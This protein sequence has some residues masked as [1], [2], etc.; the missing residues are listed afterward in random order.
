[1]WKTGPPK[2]FDFCHLSKGWIDEFLVWQSATH[3]ATKL[4]TAHWAKSA[5]NVQKLTII[6][7]VINK[8]FQIYLRFLTQCAGFKKN[9]FSNYF[10][11]FGPLC[12]VTLSFIAGHKRFLIVK[13]FPWNQQDQNICPAVWIRWVK[14]RAVR[15]IY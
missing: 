13:G 4:D 1:M 7:N 8:Y 3:M 12:T 6:E 11:S 14:C 15:K 2:N 10:L 9:R 5:K